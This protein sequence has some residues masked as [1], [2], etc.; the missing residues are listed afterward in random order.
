MRVD[1]DQ[2]LELRRRVAALGGRGRGRRFPPTLR[3]EIAGFVVEARASGLSGAEACRQL[4]VPW[5]SVTRWI[6]ADE[7]SRGRLRPVVV[8]SE[9]ARAEG[10]VLRTEH[11]TIEGLDVSGLVELL[12]QLR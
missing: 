12:R 7:R 3:A 10:L 5:E 8:R 9:V 2:V 6:A 11:F 4:D 1:S